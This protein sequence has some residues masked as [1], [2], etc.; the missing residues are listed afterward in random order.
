MHEMPQMKLC[1]YVDQGLGM[2]QKQKTTGPQFVIQV[3]DNL[4]LCRF[5]KVDDYVAAKDNIHLFNENQLALIE[6]IQLTEI[7]KFLDFIGN[8]MVFIYPVEVSLDIFLV[9]CSE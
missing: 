4:S 5:V 8:L 3:L 1:R 9:R 7:D 2:S 6:Q